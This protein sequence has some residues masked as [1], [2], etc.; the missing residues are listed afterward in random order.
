MAH[1]KVD[2]GYFCATGEFSQEA[3]AFAASNPI[4]LISGRD[5]LEAIA[6]MPEQIRRDLLAVSTTGDYTTPT[7]ASCGIKLVER[8]ISG[9]AA[10]GCL[11]YPRCR[12]KIFS[13]I[14]PG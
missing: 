3:I 1:E 5:L 13:K 2:R 4:K 6:Q 8:T 9:R 14:R 11:N 12:M 10:W 7:C